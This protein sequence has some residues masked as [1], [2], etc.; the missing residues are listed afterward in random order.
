M[1]GKPRNLPASV[2]Q[3]LMIL[4]R[5]QNEDFQLVLTRFV[6]ERFLYRL[7]QSEYKAE[8]VLKGAMLFR[9]WTDQIYRPT[10]DVDL[11]GKGDHSVERLAR[12]I[13]NVC[14]TTVPDDGLEFVADA[15]VAEP[16]KE[17]QEYEGV[18]VKCPVRLETAEIQLQIDIGFGD[19]VIPKPISVEYPALLEFPA[20][21]VSAYSRET[22]VAEKFQ[23]MVQLGIANSRMKDF[24][25]L[26]ILARQFGF[27]GPLLCQAI[28]ATFE[29]RR[30]A[31]PADSPL[32]LTAEFGTDAAKMKQWVAFVKKGK[33]D[34]QGQALAQICERLSDFLMPPAKALSDGTD[35][36]MWWPP[37]GPWSARK[38]E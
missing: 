14:A 36:Q 31:V 11:L 20:P 10:R 5:K 13:Q 26:W 25:D 19:A 4:A 16:I 38:P 29:R 17:D 21:T 27:E 18:R 35:F 1:K 23:A 30:T 24:F 6:I 12:V 37:N 32:A 3:R 33:L 2:R 8:F 15:I 28:H 7:S 9:L 34:V 22:V